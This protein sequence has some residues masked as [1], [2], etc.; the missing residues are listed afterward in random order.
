MAGGVL[1]VVATPIG[2]LEDLTLRALRVLREVD[3]IA[4]EDTRH[5][6]VL[7]SRHGI[8]RP[9]TS[10]YDAVERARAPGIVEKLKAGARV[11]LVS[12]AGTPGI[13]DPGYH[14]VRGALAAGVSVVPV[15]GR[16]ALTA[17]VS[18]AGF[19]AERFVFEGFLPSRPGPRAARLAALAREPRALLSFEAARRLAAF[20]AAAEA[21]LGDREAAVARELTKRHEEILRGRFSELRDRVARHAS[22]RGEVTVLVAGA[23]ETEPA[24]DVASLDEELRAGRAAGRGRRE[25]AAGIAPRTGLGRRA[26]YPPGPALQQGEKGR[27]L[28]HARTL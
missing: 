18:V 25:L 22:L 8:S 21:A 20:L 7:L 9:V 11:A 17:L 2:N 1:Y 6:R 16:S 23:P 15:P 28:A 27:P 26:G 3:L 24:R 13:A 5:T 10:Y 12:D 19:P 4:A 14:L